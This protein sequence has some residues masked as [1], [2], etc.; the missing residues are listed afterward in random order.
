MQTSKMHVSKSIIL[1]ALLFLIVIASIVLSSI[2]LAKSSKSTSSSTPQAF[3]LFY[4]QFGGQSQPKTTFGSFTFIYGL[5]PAQRTYLFSTPSPQL[6]DDTLEELEQNGLFN[7]PPIDGT[8]KSTLGKT[9]QQF[10]TTNDTNTVLNGG[11]ADTDA[12]GDMEATYVVLT[13]TQKIMQTISVTQSCGYTFVAKINA[14]ADTGGTCVVTLYDMMKNKR[15]QYSPVQQTTSPGS[16]KFTITQITFDVFLNPGDYTLEISGETQ[17]SDQQAIAVAQ[18]SFHQSFVGSHIVVDL[19]YVY[20]NLP[21]I[22]CTLA[23]TPTQVSDYIMTG[24]LI[25]QKVTDPS[26]QLFSGGYSKLFTVSPQYDTTSFFVAA[27]AGPVT[28]PGASPFPPDTKGIVLTLNWMAVG[29]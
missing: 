25:T 15:Y 3:P 24:F 12:F 21:T 26:Q 10:W 16:L 13:Q 9:P 11:T 18:I 7:L 27:I 2:A 23:T 20:Q 14:K 6:R 8:T 22:S 17:T 5:M 19:P 1:F 28:T 29:V 4:P